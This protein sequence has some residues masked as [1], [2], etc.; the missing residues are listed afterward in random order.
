MSIVQQGNISWADS[1][2]YDT[3]DEFS[4]SGTMELG[5]I[6]YNTPLNIPSNLTL[7][8]A[9]SHDLGT[10]QAMQAPIVLAI[11]YTTDPA[12]SYANESAPSSQWRRPYY[13]SQYADDEALVIL[14][15]F[16]EILVLTSCFRLLT[17]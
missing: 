15:I 16:G 1:W 2:D 13:K 4:S 9:F 17:F 7:F 11:G 12:I 8:F 10:I 6:A 3:I 14:C 5:G